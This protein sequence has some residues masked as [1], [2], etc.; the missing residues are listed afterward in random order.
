[1]VG[2]K[3]VVLPG[4]AIVALTVAD[5]SAK[6]ERR[7][8]GETL[9]ETDALG[10]AALRG[11]VIEEFGW[12][13]ITGRTRAAAEENPG[14][15]SGGTPDDTS[16]IAPPPPEAEPVG[17]PAFMR[18]DHHWPAVVA[19]HIIEKPA[20]ALPSFAR[21][22]PVASPI[23]AFGAPAFL[24]DADIF[25]PPV[26]IEVVAPA[27]PEERPTLSVVDAIP[28]RIADFGEI[29][30]PGNQAFVAVKGREATL[31]R[32]GVTKPRKVVGVIVEKTD[33]SSIVA[34]VSFLETGFVPVGDGEGFESDAALAR[35]RLRRAAI[36]PGEAIEWLEPPS[37]SSKAGR[38]SYCYSVAS[39]DGAAPSGICEAWALGRHGAV[40][41]AFAP[42][43][44]LLSA[45]GADAAVNMRNV[46]ARWLDTILFDT[47]EAYADFDPRTDRVSAFL[48]EDLIEKGQDAQ[49]IAAIK[50]RV[51]FSGFR[52]HLPF[53][54]GVL[55]GVIAIGFA[56][57]SVW[58]RRRAL[59]TAN[60]D[61][62]NA[63]PST[64]APSFLAP[65]VARL[66]G[67][68]NSRTG[69]TVATGPG[70]Y[71]PTLLAVLMK[72]R[73][74]ATAAPGATMASPRPLVTTENDSFV[75]EK[76]LPTAAAFLKRFRGDGESG[77]R[78]ARADAEAAEGAGILSERIA[79][80]RMRVAMEPVGYTPTVGLAADPPQ[81]D[82]ATQEAGAA[83]R[84]S[85][86]RGGV[87]QMPD[88]PSEILFASGQ[89]DAV[90][91]EAELARADAAAGA[92]D[93]PEPGPADAA[94][95]APIVA[96]STRE[97]QAAGIDLIEPGDIDAARAILNARRHGNRSNL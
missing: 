92:P 21:R 6:S 89:S 15:K 50:L 70:K 57:R 11:L 35:L 61:V 23:L 94:P 42:H 69:T 82:Q 18:D 52:R 14:G 26:R 20:V 28:P 51:L 58:R 95:P 72:L 24:E 77:L 10:G 62:G 90:A 45:Q 81:P 73:A 76:Y 30:L 29:R 83:Q 27:A 47:G 56:V 2:I 78:G 88:A 7:P 96:P 87:A 5:A 44:S 80:L 32:L 16:T 67:F 17:P 66:R 41:I 36:A 8:A 43:P 54:L 75:L 91:S 34:V 49:T 71:F 60:P 1:M 48:A 86:E 46:A 68:V 13:D 12:R 22:L 53:M 38:I 64:H 33:A 55:S 31:R 9:S 74:R 3:S 19:L 65:V 25:A 85:N 40:M 39:G 4:L 84:E 93:G 59:H 37:L 97:N 79:A 63:R